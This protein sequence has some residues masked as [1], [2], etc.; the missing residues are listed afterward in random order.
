MLKGKARGEYLKFVAKLTV[1]GH[2]AAGATGAVNLFAW[3]C[4]FM[5]SLPLPEA[6]TLYPTSPLLRQNKTEQGRSVNSLGRGGDT[7]LHAAAA[8]GNADTTRLLL[9]RGADPLRKNAEGE[10]PLDVARG[11]AGQGRGA[12]SGRSGGDLVKVLEGAV[13]EAEA[14]KAAAEAKK[15]AKLGAYQGER[16]ERHW[17]EG[18][19]GRWGERPLLFFFLRLSRGFGL[20]S[21][22][23]CCN[24]EI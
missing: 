21:R 7:P 20:L 24:G 13:E 3:F 15:T 1:A 14:A 8:A 16:W 4:F 17:G 9:A 2:S 22:S 6:T 18:G 11:R 23:S 10:T 5:A 12:D 19:G